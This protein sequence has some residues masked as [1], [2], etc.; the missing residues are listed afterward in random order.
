MN[1]EQFSNK[2]PRPADSVIEVAAAEPPGHF[3]YQVNQIGRFLLLSGLLRMVKIMY[4]KVFIWRNGVSCMGE[5]YL[6]TEDTGVFQSVF[7][8]GRCRCDS[9]AYAQFS[10]SDPVMNLAAEDML[11]ELVDEAVELPT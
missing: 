3:F 4:D 5:R 9:A 7:Y 1:R 6:R 8:R 10:A 11:A 2:A